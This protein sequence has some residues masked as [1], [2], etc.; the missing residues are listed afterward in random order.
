MLTAGQEAK[1]DQ[2]QAA[3]PYSEIHDE[4]AKESIFFEEILQLS[5]IISNK[6]QISQ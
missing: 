3:E 1:T 4:I 5:V 6:P 2:E